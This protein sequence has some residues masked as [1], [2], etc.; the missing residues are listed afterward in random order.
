MAKT[1]KRKSTGPRAVTSPYCAPSKSKIHQRGLFATCAIKKDTELIEYVGEKITK[2]EGDNR[3]NAL[4]EESAG[5]G[6]AAVYIFI[7]DD[8]WDIDGNVPHNTARLINHSCAPNCEAQIIDDSEIWIVSLKDIKKGEE[9]TFDYGF[10]LVHWADH[11][12]RCGMPNCVG[13]IVSQENW[14]ELKMLIA[15]KAKKKAKQAK[16]KAKQVK[17][18]SASKP[19]KKASASKPTKKSS[20]SKPTKKSSASKPTKK[21][22]ASKP[23]KK[24][25]KKTVPKGKKS[26]AKKAA[27][28]KSKKAGAKKK[29]G[30]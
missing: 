25:T 18:A 22:S 6:D 19:T 1:T 3:G 7:L 13:Y 4:V 26:P 23:T 8:Q 20:A 17:K 12:C 9:L 10:D 28:K 24:A 2:E 21:S 29:R 27:G 15:E 16:K 11:P 5:T 30:K 14:P